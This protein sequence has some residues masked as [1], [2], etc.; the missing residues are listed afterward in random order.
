MVVENLPVRRQFRNGKNPAVKE[1]PAGQRQDSSSQS[2]KWHNHVTVQ[3][4]RIP[5]H[6]NVLTFCI[7]VHTVWTLEKQLKQQTE[8]AEITAQSCSARTQFHGLKSLNSGT[9][10]YNIHCSNTYGTEQ[11]ISSELEASIS[12]VSGREQMNNGWLIGN[13]RY[14]PAQELVSSGA[15]QH[16]IEKYFSDRDC[17]I[18]ITLPSMEFLSEQNGFERVKSDTSKDKLPY[19]NYDSIFNPNIKANVTENKILNS[20]NVKD[21]RHVPS[22]CHNVTKHPQGEQ[23]WTGLQNNSINTVDK[24][25]YN[26]TSLPLIEL[27]R[28][29]LLGYEEKKFIQTS[30]YPTCS[31]VKSAVCGDNIDDTMKKENEAEVL[32]KP[33][34]LKEVHKSSK[35]QIEGYSETC[36]M[37]QGMSQTKDFKMYPDYK[38]CDIQHSNTMSQFQGQREYLERLQKDNSSFNTLGRV[39]EDERVSQGSLAVQ[40]GETDSALSSDESDNSVHSS[41][42]FTPVSRKTNPSSEHADITRASQDSTVEVVVTRKNMTLGL[43]R[44]EMQSDPD[45]SSS[46]EEDICCSGSNSG[47]IVE[48][49]ESM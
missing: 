48:A 2:V 35:N 25:G 14:C 19:M 7:P 3:T 13:N 49:L 37:M 11:S 18:S 16:E 6:M 40:Q 44:L 47:N 43:Q 8:G 1:I 5:I 26:I 28:E 45:S 12:S 10:I 30:W 36:L 22:L 41:V 27:P 38:F 46:I 23:Q 15:G 42:T 39:I 9:A 24:M 21:Y 20:C 4:D 32:Q 17:R 29:R 34:Q 33:S 31:A